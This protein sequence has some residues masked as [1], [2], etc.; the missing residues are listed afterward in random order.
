M[1]LTPAQKALLQ[2]VIDEAVTARRRNS[3][4]SARP[5]FK[6]VYDREVSDLLLLKPLVENIDGQGSTGRK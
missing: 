4:K 3:A 2:Q 6:V 5:E 1:A